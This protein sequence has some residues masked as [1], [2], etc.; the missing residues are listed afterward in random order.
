M[1]IFS[2]NLKP[3]VRLERMRPGQIDAAKADRP[4]IYI[5][6]GSIEWHGIHNP[7]GLD[8]TKAHEQL[9][10]LAAR[11][12]GVVYPPVFLGA[13]GGHMDYPHTYM[14][15]TAALIPI[16]TQLLVAFERDGYQK[17]ILLSGHY[18]NRSEFLDPAVQAYTAAGGRMEVLAI[19]E[20]QVPGGEGDHAAK[21][22]TSAMLYLH[23]DTVDMTLLDDLPG[24]EYGPDQV[25]NWMQEAYKNHPCYGLVGIDPRRYASAAVGEGMTNNL[26]DFLSG[27]LAG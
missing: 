6:F 14:I 16:V 27:W 23:P 10:G 17:A 21:Y 1:G 9:V 24:E 11:L 3:E 4:A 5:P 25:V 26:I 19:V 8:A 22:E 12:G 2:D 18:P 7:V 13:G 15:E 20:T